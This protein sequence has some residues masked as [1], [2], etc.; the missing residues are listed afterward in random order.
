MQAPRSSL[1]EASPH[2]AD[3]NADD[4]DDAEDDDDDDLPNMCLINS[5]IKGTSLLNKNFKVKIIMKNINKNYTYTSVRVQ[6]LRCLNYNYG[7][8]GHWEMYL[9]SFSSP[10]SVHK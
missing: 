3:D 7:I 8:N 6:W 4:I 2:D 1:D 9:D 10:R 5:K